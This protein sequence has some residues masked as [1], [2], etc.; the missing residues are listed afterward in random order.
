MARKGFNYIVT[1]TAVIVQRL[2]YAD[3]D[4]AAE[5]TDTLEFAVGEVPVELQNGEAVTSLAAYGLS[6]VLQDRCS[7][8]AA[9]DKFEQMT[10]TF[11]ALKEGKWKEVRVS[12]GGAKKASIDPFFAAGFA[13]FCVQS[14]KDIDANTATILLQN[15]DADKRKALRT[16]DAIKALIEAA[17]ESAAAKVDEFDV[18]SLFE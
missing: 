5:V 18:D 16:H 15:M 4:A 7:S 11:E 2:A 9:D 13:A 10:K 1:P 6:Q 12:T 3:A 17:K 8:V 14:G